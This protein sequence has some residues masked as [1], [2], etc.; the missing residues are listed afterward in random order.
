LTNFP[1]VWLPMSEAFQVDPLLRSQIPLKRESF[2]RSP[3]WPRL[4]PGISISSTNA[5]RCDRR[6]PGSGPHRSQGR[7]RSATFGPGFVPALEGARQSPRSFFSAADGN[8]PVRV[9]IASRCAGLLWREPRARQRR[10]PC[11][12]ARSTESESSGCT[13]RSADSFGVGYGAGA[14]SRLGR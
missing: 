4:G 14:C 2:V 9:V 3:S 10:L 5:T 1:G 11:G 8:R 12:G 6:A 7:K 13:D